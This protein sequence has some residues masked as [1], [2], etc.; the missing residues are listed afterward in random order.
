MVACFC[1]V[2]AGALVVCLGIMLV[3]DGPWAVLNGV[4]GWNYSQIVILPIALISMPIGALIRMILGLYFNNPRFVAL[5]AGAAIGLSGSLFVIIVRRGD[6]SDWPSIISV[7]LVAGI[8][9]GWTW[10]RVERPFLLRPDQ[11]NLQ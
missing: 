2:E 1:A 6:W 3:N 10:W 5:L 11:T 9:G 8:I 4:A 7:G